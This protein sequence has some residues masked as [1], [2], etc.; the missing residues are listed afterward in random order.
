MR[1][2]KGTSGH[3]CKQY[4][5][6]LHIRIQVYTICKKQEWDLYFFSANTVEHNF[7]NSFYEDFRT[8]LK[9]VF[10]RI[11]QFVS[12]TFRTTVYWSTGLTTTL[13]LV[14]PASRCSCLPDNAQNSLIVLTG[15]LTHSSLATL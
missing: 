2:R 15:P 4:G 13:L 1:L 3:I 8:Y 10:T 9:Y 7:S 14:F 12:W 6:S 11:Q 5:P